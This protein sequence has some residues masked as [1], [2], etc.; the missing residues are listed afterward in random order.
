[1]RPPMRPH[2]Q[3]GVVLIVALVMLAIIGLMSAAVMRNALSNDVVS[4]N[5]RRSNQ[6][7]QAAQAAL[8]YCEQLLTGEVTVPAGATALSTAAAETNPSNER[9]T[10]FSNWKLATNAGGPVSVPSTVY[11]SSKAPQCMA[12]KR[13]L[14]SSEVIVVTARGFSDNYAENSDASGRTKAGSVVWLQSI[15]RLETL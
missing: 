4:D 7:T 6:A 13:T 9:W 2:R 10:S 11:A 12:Q 3:R 5:N 15:I 14:G 8:R 1:M